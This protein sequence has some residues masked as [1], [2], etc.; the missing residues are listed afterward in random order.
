L[1]KTSSK[2]LIKY[3]KLQKFKSLMNR[4][5]ALISIIIGILFAIP[6]LERIKHCRWR[7]G[8]DISWW[9]NCTEHKINLFLYPLAFYLIFLLISEML[10]EI[11]L[12]D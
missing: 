2:D 8:D 9:I 7:A 6:T 5:R 12:R 3:F 1:E 4:R 11:S 10:E